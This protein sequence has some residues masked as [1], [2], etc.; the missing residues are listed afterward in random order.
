MSD[1]ERETR[2]KI[3]SIDSMKE[4]ANWYIDKKND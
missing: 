2:R 4:F 3:N 1:E